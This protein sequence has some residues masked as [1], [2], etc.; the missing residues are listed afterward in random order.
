MPAEPARADRPDAVD[1]PAGPGF[2]DAQRGRLRLRVWSALILAPLPVAAIWFG[3]PFLAL[4]TALAAAV[5]AWEWGRL[6]H[7]R[8]GGGA[9][10]APVNAM[11]VAVVLAAVAIAALGAAGLAVLAAGAGA[12]IVFWAAR[13]GA[14]PEPQGSASGSSASGSSAPGWSAPG[15]AALGA[16][17]VSLPCVCLLWLARQEAG[18]RATLLWLLAVVWATDTGAYAIGRAVG[19]P[20]LAP[21]L[22]PRKTWSGFAG[23]IACAALAGAATA[24]VLRLAPALPVLLS[25]GLAIV[26][27]FGDLA[28]SLAKR[29]FGVK[30]SSGLIPGHGGLLDRLDG[31]LAVI[32]AVALLTL[33]GGRGVLAW[34]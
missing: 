18:G 21:R 13:Q 32:P 5:M 4:L 28:E 1:Q 15:W 12:A 31:L 20:R 24:L 26:A 10:A 34:H 23:G 27:Q 7:G 8:R 3:A 22:S 19:G 6:C 9:P 33:I 29:R 17:W 30:D 16:L 14:R 25:A 11:L 2:A